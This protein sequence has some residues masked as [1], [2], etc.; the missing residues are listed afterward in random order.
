MRVSRG[1]AG[2][3]V[4]LRAT[5]I[6]RDVAAVYRHF[7]YPLDHLTGQLTLEK[8]TIAVN[9]QTLKGA[10]PVSLTGTIQNPGVDAVVRLDIQAEAIPIDDVL[11]SAMPADV[12]KLSTSSTPAVWSGLRPSVTRY[13]LPR[14]HRPPGRQDHDRRRD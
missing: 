14:E 7:Q 12:R 11:K 8:N 2:E 10:Q 6:C 13:P 5:V 9:L 4:D 3:P 1:E